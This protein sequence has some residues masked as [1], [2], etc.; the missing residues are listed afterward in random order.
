MTKKIPQKYPY[1][2]NILLYIKILHASQIPKEL[3]HTPKALISIPKADIVIVFIFICRMQVEEIIQI[4]RTTAVSTP[5]ILWLR[6]CI[7]ILVSL[8][9]ARHLK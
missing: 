6:N 5:L 1:K 8:E 9:A 2:T 7:S 3:I 4:T